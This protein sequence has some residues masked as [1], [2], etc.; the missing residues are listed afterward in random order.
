MRQETYDLIA[1]LRGVNVEVGEDAH[2]DTLVITHD[3]E[4]DVLGA[5]VVVGQSQCFA[6]R[7]L[8]DLLARGVNGIWPEVTSSLGATMR[9]T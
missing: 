3:S 4:Q 9:T 5:D 6:Q 2:R 7:Q 8:E 1:N